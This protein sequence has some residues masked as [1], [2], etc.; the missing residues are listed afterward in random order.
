VVSEPE[1]PASVPTLPAEA[2][3]EAFGA[4][5]TSGP[6]SGEDSPAE[7]DEESA[8][9]GASTADAAKAAHAAPAGEGAGVM[10]D[11]AGADGEPEEGEAAGQPCATCG[12]PL[13]GTAKFCEA[14]GAPVGGADVST[15]PAAG[16]EGGEDAGPPCTRC[17]A[18]V[19]DDGY[20]TSCGHRALEPV[21][22]DDQGAAAYA[23]HRGRRHNRNEDAAALAT[24][25]EG[26]PVLVVSDGVSVSPN[27]DKA[28]AAAVEAAATRLAGR[29][30]AGD[31]D[32]VAA[33]ELAHEAASA[34]PA[35]GDPNWVD[36]GTHPACTIVVAVVTPTDAHMANVGDARGYVLTATTPAEAEAQPGT[37]PAP[38]WSATQVT[39]DD[40]VAAEAVAEG[41]DPDIA[42]TLEGGHAITAWLGADAT[43]AE[44]H[45]AT[46]PVGPDDVVVVSSDG[47]WNYATTDAAL[48]GLASAHLP[49]P[50]A[51]SG[52][53]GPLCEDLVTWANGRGGADNI[54][55]TIAHVPREDGGAE[56][57]EPE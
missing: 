41:V 1:G 16:P 28:S 4:G 36:D 34:V 56:G 57:E 14:C 19:G 29:P 38:A 21:T 2:D 17:G 22:V 50:G 51:P 55:V 24:T 43:G 47:L 49:P 6:T 30:F 32:L 54:T 45:L 25:S 39:T 20:C 23:T 15:S 42:L 40:S 5:A 7:E 46:H 18:E 8:A 37:E 27:P 26:W 9:S 44:V 11:E 53:L 48:G 33:V 3:D 12:E 52:A 35:T 13:V 10:S 31:D